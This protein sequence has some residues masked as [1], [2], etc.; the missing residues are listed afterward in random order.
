MQ[1]QSK[2]VSV[3]WISTVDVHFLFHWNTFFNFIRNRVKHV[4][5]LWMACSLAMAVRML[6]PLIGRK[7]SSLITSEL[8]LLP[9][10]QKQRLKTLLFMLL[11]CFPSSAGGA[12]KMFHQM[13]TELCFPSH[14]IYRG[15]PDCLLKSHHGTTML[16]TGFCN[17][18][19]EIRTDWAPQQDCFIQ[20]ISFQI[21]TF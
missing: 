19:G 13:P 9:V 10:T 2:P 17:S 8:A 1:E 4:K 16:S 14:I 3:S 20:C 7:K 6:L 18:G 11:Y 5:F 12:Y 21:Q 15:R